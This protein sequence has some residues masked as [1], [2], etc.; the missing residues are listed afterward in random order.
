MR[1][2]LSRT[3]AAIDRG[4][5]LRRTSVHVVKNLVVYL[6]C[7]LAVRRSG[8]I[9]C[10]V[11]PAGRKELIELQQIPIAFLAQ[12]LQYRARL[13]VLPCPLEADTFDVISSSS[14]GCAPR[15]PDATSPADVAPSSC[16]SLW[17][18]TVIS[19]NMP[20]RRSKIYLEVS[21][22]LSSIA[23]TRFTR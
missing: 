13:A 16:S 6:Y 2:E 8:R 7:L 1:C 3:F 12:H 20:R 22:A 21:L 17:I 10:S 5:N 19:P 4:G 11:L 14:K 23:S 15:A 18:N 9:D